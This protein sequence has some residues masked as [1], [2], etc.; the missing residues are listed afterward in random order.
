MSLNL[1]IIYITLIKKKY[2]IQFWIWLIE[3]QV[4]YY[5]KQKKKREK[6]NIT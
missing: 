5:K 6:H 2:I 3:R 1:I 4:F